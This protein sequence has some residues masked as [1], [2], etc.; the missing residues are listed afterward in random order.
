MRRIARRFCAISP[1]SGC[2]ACMS[3]HLTGKYSEQLCCEL[4][5]IA[6]TE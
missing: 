3:R 6:L 4:D 5:A 1:S 2:Y